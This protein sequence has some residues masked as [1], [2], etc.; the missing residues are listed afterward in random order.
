[1]SADPPL[2][3][4]DLALRIA[5]EQLRLAQR[6]IERIRWPYFMIEVFLCWLL[7][8]L[9]L[10]APALAWFAAVVVMQIWRWRYARQHVADEQA[11]PA[12]VLQRLASFLLV[13][14]GLRALIVPLLFMQPLQYEHFMFTLVYLGMI[15]GTSASVGG[16]LRPFLLY[17]LLSGGSLAVGYGLQGTVESI[18]VGVLILSLIAVLGAHL[19]DQTKGLAKFVQLVISRKS[20]P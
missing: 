14:G 10:G 16:Q 9:G 3:G 19:N 12:R 7:V 13:L 6:Q 11:D 18:W 17:S 2:P 1:V 8:R 15:A 5:R 4:D 20:A